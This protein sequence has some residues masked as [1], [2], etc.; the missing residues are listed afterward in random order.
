LQQGTEK[1]DVQDSVIAELG[2]AQ[3]HVERIHY[4]HFEEIRMLCR[5]EQ[6]PL[7][8]ELSAELAAIF[9]GPPG[10]RRGR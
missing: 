10:K 5:P 9:S 6:L 7:F 2:A 8:N 1:P 4:R 3:Q